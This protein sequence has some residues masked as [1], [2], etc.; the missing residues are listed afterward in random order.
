MQAAGCVA[1]IQ[2]PKETKRH[3]V[4]VTDRGFDPAQLKVKPSEWIVFKVDCK[5]LKRFILTIGDEESKLL[6]SGDMFESGQIQTECKYECQINFF[7]GVVRV[8]TI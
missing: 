4:Y 5:A 1:S 6:K 7:K 2:R 3:T 8:D